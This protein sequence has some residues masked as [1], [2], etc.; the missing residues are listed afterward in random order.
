MFDLLSHAAAHRALAALSVSLIAL[1]TGCQ[2]R[3]GDAPTTEVSERRTRQ[4][5]PIGKRRSK[6]GMPSSTRDRNEGGTPGLVLFVVMDTVRADHTSL[7]SY[8]RPTTPT[9]TSLARKEGFVHTCRAY[10]PAPWTLPSHAS[11]FTGRSVTDHAAM[12]VAK[13]D[14]KVHDTISVRPLASE[15]T[16]L[17]ERFAAEGFQTAAITAN[18]IVNEASGLLQGFDHTLVSPGMQGLRERKLSKG[19]TQLL[20]PVDPNAPLFLFVNIYDAHDPYPP[21]PEGVGWVPAQE[22]VRLDAYTRDLDNPYFAFLEGAMP[23]DV[24]QPWLQTLTNGYDY[25]IS[26]ADKNVASILTTLEKGGFL[27]NG[28]RIAITSDHGEFLGEHGKLRHSGFMWE[29]GV[30][31]PFLYQDSTLTVQPTLPEPF[32]TL[33]VHDLLL[34]GALP[35]PVLPPETISEKNP[36]D[37]LVGEVGAATW[38]GELKVMCRDGIHEQYDLSTDP[39]E[40]EP[41]AVATSVQPTLDALCAR[42]DALHK[43]PPPAADAELMQMLEAAGYVEGEN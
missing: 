22:R 36:D 30:N 5:A 6:A 4:S 42:V 8:A 34:T 9:L 16:T 15:E 28:W 40:S 10:S 2:C 17:A 39:D 3:G 7:C 35:D 26:R 27:E 1:S 11:F 37:L 31:V 19:L 32:G 13:S 23:D 41:Q 25:G 38:A 14:V 24:R 20:K 29:P 12:F 33:N 43:L 21:I 18:I